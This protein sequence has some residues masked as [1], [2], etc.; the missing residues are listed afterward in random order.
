MEAAILLF[1]LAFAAA[2]VLPTW[3]FGGFQQ[4]P[5]EELPR[6]QAGETVAYGEFEIEPIGAK[7]VD[8]HP[9]GEFKTKEGNAYL[10]VQ[11][12]VENLTKD[13]AYTF[14]ELLLLR[15]PVFTE[16][17]PPNDSGLVRDGS[18][19]SVLHPRVPETLQLVW[20]IPEEQASKID[21]SLDMTLQRRVYEESFFEERMKWM[22]PR[23][24]L[25]VAMPVV[26]EDA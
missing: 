18:A 20:E 16:R 15:Q 12:T 22:A 6:I 23:P 24:W 17:T 19:S 9:M 2:V 11:V 5:K 21:D 25:T 7:L 14:D 26:R 10:V 8:E 13:T 3:L 1:V 4:Q